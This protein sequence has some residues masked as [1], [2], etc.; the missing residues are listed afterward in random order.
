MIALFVGR[1]LPRDTSVQELGMGQG[2]LFK[3]WWFAL[4]YIAPI[5]IILV[6]LNSLKLI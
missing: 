4:R 6:F 3:Y 2:T 1:I 5:G